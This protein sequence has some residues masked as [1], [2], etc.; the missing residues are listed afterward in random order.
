MPTLRRRTT[1][2]N[3]SQDSLQDIQGFHDMQDL[4]DLQSQGV[5]R[6]LHFMG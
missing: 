6:E 5:K 1:T 2:S 4:Q 3:Q